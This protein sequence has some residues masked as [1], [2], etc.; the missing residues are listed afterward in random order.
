[1]ET[2]T[3][4]AATRYDVLTAGTIAFRH[5]V[6]AERYTVMVDNGAS[7]DVIAYGADG[8]GFCRSRHGLIL[9]WAPST[10]ARRKY[11]VP[12]V[13]TPGRDTG[14]AAGTVTFDQSLIIDGSTGESFIGWI[15]TD[16]AQ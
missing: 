5:L 6:A 4:L 13:L 12:V 16:L 3:P 11:M 8:T 9:R 2:L 7:F 15:N 10:K 14:D 1:M